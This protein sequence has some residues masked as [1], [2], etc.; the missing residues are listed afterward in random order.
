MEMRKFFIRPF[1]PEKIHALHELSMNLWSYWDKD[2]GKLFRRLDPQLFRATHHNAV[3]LLCRLST[4]RLEEMAKDKGFLH[5]LKE[6][7]DAF[8]AYME[9]E[10]SFSP[11]N[12]TAYI[13]TEYGLHESVP[14]YS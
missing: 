8:K 9:F 4:A 11:D 3:E 10:S 14:I 1:I 7:Y 2:A 13:C 6:V 5:D 12:L